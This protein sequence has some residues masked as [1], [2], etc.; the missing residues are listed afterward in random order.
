M[1]EISQRIR[2]R[3]RVSVR[4]FWS[5][6]FALAASHLEL[7][8]RIEVLD[9]DWWDLVRYRLRELRYSDLGDNFIAVL[10]GDDTYVLADQQGRDYRDTN[11]DI[12][13][14]RFSG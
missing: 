6:L 2:S 9:R 1:R 13:D 10:F 5:W 3:W 12:R 11:R 4:K 14:N 7:Q 8:D